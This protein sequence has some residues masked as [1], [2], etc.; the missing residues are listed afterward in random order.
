MKCANDVKS[1]RPYFIRALLDW[2]VDSGCTPHLLIAADAEGVSVPRDHVRDGRIVLNLS[3]AAVRNFHLDDAALSFDSR[4]GGQ[5]FHV[6]APLGAVAAVYAKENGEGMA[7]E[8]ESPNQPPPD[9]AQPPKG[10]PNL[11]LVK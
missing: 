2:I 10:A 8:V 1:S 6:V 4:F 11:K 7:F 5:S 9:D 3:A